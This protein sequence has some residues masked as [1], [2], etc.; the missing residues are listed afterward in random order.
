MDRK[1]PIK[2]VD[3][4]YQVKSPNQGFLAKPIGHK[5]QFTLVDRDDSIRRADQLK[6][7]R[8]EAWQRYYLSQT[9][10]WNELCTLLRNNPVGSRADTIAYGC[11]IYSWSV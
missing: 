7:I 11:T 3:Q 4:D 10:Y 2:F 9:L 6:A 1:R 5:G 8:L